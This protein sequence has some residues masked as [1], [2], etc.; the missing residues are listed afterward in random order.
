M[1]K[2]E[3]TEPLAHWCS[4]ESSH[5]ELFNE[6]QY[7]RVKMI[8]KNANDWLNEIDRNIVSLLSKDWK[9]KFAELCLFH[10]IIFTKKV[11]S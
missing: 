9:R 3:T 1:Q 8:F 6:Y 11:H 4:S 10:G 7:D 2:T 5:Q